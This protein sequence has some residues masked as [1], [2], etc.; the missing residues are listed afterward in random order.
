MLC[1]RERLLKTMHYGIP[2]PYQA[3]L[4]LSRFTAPMPRSIETGA[5]RDD[6]R[7][8]GIRYQDNANMAIQSSPSIPVN[9]S[10]PATNLRDAPGYTAG[11]CGQGFSLITTED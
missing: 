5:N 3:L 11:Q 8:T 7:R 10:P 6:N 4:T 9:V 2:P 1:C